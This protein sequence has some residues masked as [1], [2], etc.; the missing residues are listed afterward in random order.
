M[1]PLSYF[2]YIWLWISGYVYL[3]RMGGGFNQ[4]FL[5]QRFLQEYLRYYDAKIHR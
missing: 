5:K 3:G 2:K 4:S 1:K